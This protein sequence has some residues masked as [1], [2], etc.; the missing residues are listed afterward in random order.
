MSSKEICINNVPME[1]F[2]EH[3]KNEVDYKNCKTFEELVEKVDE[4]M[5]IT[6]MRGINKSK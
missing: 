3:F 5:Y 4:Y 2:L 6:T 1:S